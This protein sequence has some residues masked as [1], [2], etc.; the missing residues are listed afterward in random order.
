MGQ[1]FAAKSKVIQVLAIECIRIKVD[2]QRFKQL[3]KSGGEQLLTG[4]FVLFKLPP[5]ILVDRL[6]KLVDLVGEGETVCLKGADER[7][8]FGIG[9]VHQGFVRIDE[10]NIIF[11]EKTSIARFLLG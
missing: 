2:M 8:M 10:K 6:I 3:C 11:H 5:E 9:E 4:D 7:L 1:G